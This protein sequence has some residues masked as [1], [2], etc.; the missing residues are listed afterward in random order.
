MTAVKRILRYLKH[1]LDIG[2]K[3]TKSSSMHVSAFLDLDWAGDDDDDRRSIRGFAVC[4]GR[5]LFYWSARKQHTVSRSSTETEYKTLAN[6]TAELMWVETLLKELRIHGPPAARIW[7]DNIGATYL[8]VNSVFHGRTKYVEVDFHF[9]RERV[10]DKLPD[11]RIIST[12]DQ[13]ADGFTKPLTT[14]KLV[15]FRSNLNLCKL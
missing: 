9:V 13:V 14:K 8:I 4:L 3:F 11:V 10:A 1:T 12:D 15:S 5:N 6:A 2:L 7:C